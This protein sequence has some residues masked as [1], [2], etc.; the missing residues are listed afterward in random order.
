MITCGFSR[1]V[2]VPTFCDCTNEETCVSLR[3]E[4]KPLQLL[5]QKYTL[6]NVFNECNLRKQNRYS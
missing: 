3:L 2:Y 4:D 5:Q 1:T 6:A